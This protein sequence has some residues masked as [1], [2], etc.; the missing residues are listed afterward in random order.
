MLLTQ[1]IA[2]KRS[3]E[4][5]KDEAIKKTGE[6]PNGICYGVEHSPAGCFCG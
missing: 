5:E 2:L 4:G 6:F 3:G 1:C